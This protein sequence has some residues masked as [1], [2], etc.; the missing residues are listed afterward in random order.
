MKGAHN[1]EGCRGIYQADMVQ[2]RMDLLLVA[3]TLPSPGLL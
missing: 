2:A 1:I 3:M